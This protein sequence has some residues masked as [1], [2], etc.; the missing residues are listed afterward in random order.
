M[1]LRAS[2]VVP[3]QS[4]P[5]LARF[6][7]SDRLGHLCNRHNVPKKK[8]NKQCRSG[9][10]VRHRVCAHCFL[11]KLCAL[12]FQPIH[13]RQK[14]AV[15]ADRT[16]CTRDSTST[17]TPRRSSRAASTAGVPFGAGD[18]AGPPA[19][20]PGGPGRP[21]PASP[22]SPSLQPA[23]TL[24]NIKCYR[25]HYVGTR[26]PGPQRRLERRG[27]LFCY[28]VHYPGTHVPGRQRRWGTLFVTGYIIRVHVYPDDSD[29]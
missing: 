16:H 20:P 25:V 8:N 10:T 4:L 19:E 5:A 22:F 1:N 9:V 13:A 12:L 28:R 21:P 15:Y 11:C 7:R 18:L 3:S 26:V 2:V 6:A 14:R 24:R 17:L 29:L 27:T 23:E